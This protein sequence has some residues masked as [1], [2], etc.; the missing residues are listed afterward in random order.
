MREG[1]S[2]GEESGSS[3]RAS[4]CKVARLIIRAIYLIP[5]FKGIARI[6]GFLNFTILGAFCT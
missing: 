4:F 2:V 1:R 6:C 3:S 5:K